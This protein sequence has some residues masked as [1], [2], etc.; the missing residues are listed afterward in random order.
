VA[1]EPVSL[2]PAWEW[3]LPESLGIIGLHLI[4]I[5]QVNQDHRSQRSWIGEW[6]ISARSQDSCR[7][8]GLFQLAR[9]LALREESG[10]SIYQEQREFPTKGFIFPP[11]LTRV[12][13]GCIGMSDWNEY[14]KQRE[15]ATSARFYVSFAFHA[16]FLSARN[17]W[18]ASGS[19]SI[20]FCETACTGAAFFVR[21]SQ[22]VDACAY[23]RSAINDLGCSGV[24]DFD[25]AS[26]G[27]VSHARPLKTPFAIEIADSDLSL[28]LK[29]SSRPY[30]PTQPP[31]PSCSANTIVADVGRPERRPI[32]IPRH[33]NAPDTLKRKNSSMRHADDVLKKPRRTWRGR[34]RF[35]CVRN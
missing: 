29:R 12:F 20:P 7:N 31:G 17:R 5:E 21:G 15:E 18:F 16:D 33:G 25:S 32:R 8:F 3:K 27:T 2:S 30:P 28:L 13:D 11:E 1:S 4:C 14:N 9:D 22:Y 26:Q 6:S 34:S 23:K 24:N 10:A 19:I 35:A